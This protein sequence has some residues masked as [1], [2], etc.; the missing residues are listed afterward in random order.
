MASIGDY[1]KGKLEKG[2]KVSK[3]LLK[4]ANKHDL[5][6]DDLVEDDS[7]EDDSNK[8]NSNTGDRDLNLSQMEAVSKAV[9][10]RFSLWQ[11]CL[12]CIHNRFLLHVQVLTYVHWKSHPVQSK[13]NKHVNHM[14]PKVAV[15][16]TLSNVV[17][18]WCGLCS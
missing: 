13:L 4:K 12:R 6:E 5:E 15:Q 2:S 18:T 7:E 10:R 17:E 9:M 3:S 1:I 14:K 16:H 11:V 8:I